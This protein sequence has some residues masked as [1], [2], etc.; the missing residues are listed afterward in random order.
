MNAGVPVLTYKTMSR[1]FPSGNYLKYKTTSQKKNNRGFEGSTNQPVPSRS[2]SK[3]KTVNPN[4]KIMGATKVITNGIKFDSRLESY[5]YGRLNMLKIPFEMQ[6]VYELQPK[7]R[8]HDEN[9]R[10]VRIIVDFYLPKHNC[11]IDTKGFAT[12][13]NK[14]QIKLLKY[15]L[16]IENGTDQLPK[17]HLPANQK[18]CDSILIKLG[19]IK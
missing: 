19:I 4:K 9:I 17:I 1:N 18:E 7:F 6:K 11:I 10:N 3:I 5:M 16:Y 2:V 14:L 12:D 8:Y 13:K 15:L